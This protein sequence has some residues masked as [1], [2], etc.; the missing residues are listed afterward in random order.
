MLVQNKRGGRYVFGDEITC[1]DVFLYPQIY[2]AK[3]RFNLDLTPFP[4]VTRIFNA[5]AL[6]KA[7][8]D[9]APEK[10]KDFD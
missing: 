8:Q 4:N 1:A 7:F 5:L 6:E 10:Q 2:N 9:S 3:N